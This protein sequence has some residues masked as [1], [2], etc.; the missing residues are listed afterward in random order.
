[1]VCIRYWGACLQSNNF[2][3]AFNWG[4]NRCPAF[5]ELF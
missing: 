1:M 5:R 4:C 2:V 3:A